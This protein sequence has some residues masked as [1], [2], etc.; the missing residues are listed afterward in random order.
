MAQNGHVQ[1]EM[2]L[3]GKYRSG[4]TGKVPTEFT[5]PPAFD[6]KPAF[7]GQ[8]KSKQLYGYA[9][10]ESHPTPTDPHK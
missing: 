2:A 7:D 5:Q 6:I 1:D 10:Q 9:K 8:D 4:F 3:I